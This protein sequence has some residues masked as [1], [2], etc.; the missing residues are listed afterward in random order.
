MRRLGLWVSIEYDTHSL[1]LEAQEPP[2]TRASR[3]H[4]QCNSSHSLRPRQPLPCFFPQPRATLAQW[5]S[6]KRVRIKGNGLDATTAAPRAFCPRRPV[7]PFAVYA[8]VGAFLTGKSFQPQKRSK[9]QEEM[10]VTT[11]SLLHPWHLHLSLLATGLPP[12]SCLLHHL[13]R[14]LKSLTNYRP[15]LRHARPLANTLALRAAFCPILA[16]V[17]SV[18]EETSLTG[19]DLFCA[20]AASFMSF[21]GLPDFSS[22]KQKDLYVSCCA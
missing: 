21:L 6:T 1:K 3:K 7:G 8:N 12:I 10:S 17:G 5:Q 13:A 2:C 15:T 11:R 9:L 14:P 22:Q 16:V 20:R 18:L 4:S 19:N